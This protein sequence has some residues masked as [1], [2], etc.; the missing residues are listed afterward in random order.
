MAIWEH[1]PQ[2]PP[3]RGVY[4]NAVTPHLTIGDGGPI[5]EMRA[6]AL[7]IDAQLPVRA[8]ATEVRLIVGKADNDSWRTDEAFAFQRRT[9]AESQ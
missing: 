4:G 7:Q 6:A 1:F 8:T 2:A 3:Y 5:E 9:G